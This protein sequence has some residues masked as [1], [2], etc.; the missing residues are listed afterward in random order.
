[1]NTATMNTAT[2]APLALDAA[3]AL[4]ADA[5]MA[6]RTGE[7]NA[8]VTAAALVAAE[9]D[10]IASHGLARLAAYAQQAI[11][12]K[13]D[14][15]AE[16]V[17]DWTGPATLRVDAGTG[18]AFPAIGQGL[19]AAATRARETGVVAVAVRASHHAGVMGHHVE[20][21]ADQGLVGLAFS[22]SPAAIAPW[23]GSRGVFGTNPI[24]FAVPRGEGPALVIDASLSKVA[25]GKIMIAA[26]KGAPIPTDWALDAQGQPT[27][28]AKA[29]LAGTM[30][31]IGDAK[32]AALVLMVEILATVLTGG[33]FGFEASS[34]FTAEGPAPR[35]GQL[36]LA[37]DPVRLGGADFPARL[38]VLLSAILGQDG[39]RLP[40]ER[41]IAAR[42][43]AERDGI[44][45]DPEIL[46]DLFR[47][48]GRA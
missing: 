2:K 34:F 7:N 10:G 47:R 30:L 12:G 32:G 1:M 40:G 9:A 16:P 18:F 39:T 20:W 19:A 22:N 36:F 35:I 48:A 8:R 46:A 33:Q 45:V 26:Q 17:L 29:A 25:R 38:E 14:G 23:G 42:Q 13:I 41:R 5:L 31:P 3:R 4:A 44:Q 24:A 6:S 28:D 15:F 27:G 11:S 21:L 37:L 43:R